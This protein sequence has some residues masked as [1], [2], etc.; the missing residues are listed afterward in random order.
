V[1]GL[2]GG[3]LLTGRHGLFNCYEAFVR[4]IDSIGQ[5]ARQ[6]A[7]GLRGAALAPGHLVAQLHL[8]S[9]VWQ[10]DHNGFTHQDPGF[11]D[12]VVNKKASIVRVY[13]R[14]MPTACCLLSTTACAAGTTSTWWSQAN[15][16]CR[17][18]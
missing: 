17:S 8:A 15:T 14:P 2:A 3:Y 1:R 16:P 9:H 18:G 12:H 11:I 7:E 6:V 5:P 4:I 13:L 10:Q